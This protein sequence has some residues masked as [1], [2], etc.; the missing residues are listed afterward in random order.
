M[1]DVHVTSPEEEL[2]EELEGAGAGV[3]GHSASVPTSAGK[4]GQK[5]LGTAQAAPVQPHSHSQTRLPSAA[6][7]QRPLAP[8]SWAQPSTTEAVMLPVMV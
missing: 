4:R 8:Q 1:G 5:P 2:E 6:L 3:A 7:A